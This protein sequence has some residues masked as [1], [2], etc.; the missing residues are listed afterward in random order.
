MR[1]SQI[2]IIATFFLAGVAYGQDH[3]TIAYKFLYEILTTD[4]TRSAG[5]DGSSVSVHPVIKSKLAG[6][7]PEDIKLK[8]KTESKSEDIIIG[9]DGVFNL[10]ISSELAAADAWIESDQPE[11][12]L[13]LSVTGFFYLGKIKAI[14][15]EGRGRCRYTQFFPIDSIREHVDEALTDTFSEV[16]YRAKLPNF[17][18][19]RLKNSRVDDGTSVSVVSAGGTSSIAKNE[20]GNFMIE[21]D[22]HLSV[23]S[24]FVELSPT[25]GWSWRAKPAGME[26][27]PW[28]EIE[29]TSDGS[30]QTG[31]PESRH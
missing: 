23:E 11:G 4:Y 25:T 30:E 10:P 20:H 31:A 27:T 9:P 3:Q 14:V 26:W 24:S 29:V 18:R 17:R 12:S 13:S 15:T 2:L 16:R 6:V 1:H 21:Y 7:K 5:H 19:V 28:T 8:L 22:S